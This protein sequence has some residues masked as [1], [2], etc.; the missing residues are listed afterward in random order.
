MDHVLLRG[1]WET[2]P[3]H[4]HSM[5]LARILGRLTA[6]FRKQSRRGIPKGGYGGRRIRIEL[7]G[8]EGH[9]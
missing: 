3:P 4:R 6:L 8:R 1:K 9:L 5:A 2:L 7:C